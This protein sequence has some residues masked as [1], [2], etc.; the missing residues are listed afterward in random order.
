MYSC[1]WH[2][3]LRREPMLP[4]GL[5]CRFTRLKTKHQACNHILIYKNVIPITIAWLNQTYSRIFRKHY[6]IFLKWICCTETLQSSSYSNTH[7]QLV[8]P[9]WHITG[10]GVFSNLTVW[11]QLDIYCRLVLLACS[12][13]EEQ[14]ELNVRGLC[15]AVETAV[16]CLLRWHTVYK[17]AVLKLRNGTCPSFTVT[18]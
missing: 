15:T 9:S 12:W 14:M 1:S 3:T 6:F 17:H 10:F 18:V 16:K 7:S 2:E 5:C 4:P 13:A 11:W 8:L